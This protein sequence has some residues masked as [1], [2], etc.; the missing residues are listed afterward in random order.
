MYFNTNLNFYLLFEK[1][2][3]MSNGQ[4]VGACFAWLFL[5]FLFEAIKNYRAQL[6]KQCANG[7]DKS[8]MWKLFERKYCLASA[9]YA[10]QMVLAYFVM[11][12]A[13]SYNVWVFVSIIAGLGLGKFNSFNPQKTNSLGNWAFGAMNGAGSSASVGD[14][15]G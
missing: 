1:W 12:A 10:A 9:L 2:M 11:L 15:C 4:L 14:C 7:S 8:L 3:V 5:S 6:L 13:M